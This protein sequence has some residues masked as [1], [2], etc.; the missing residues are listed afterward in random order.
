MKIKNYIPNFITSLNMLSGFVSIIL[1]TQN[2]YHLAIVF[3]LLAALFDVL[4]GL[5]ARYLNSTSKIG[6]QLD[7][8]SDLVSFGVAPA[9]LLYH[10]KLNELGI[11][12][13]IISGLFM[14]MG[15]FR[16]ARFNVQLVGFNKDYFSGIPIPTGAILL[17]SF[18]YNFVINI[19]LNELNNSYYLAAYSLFISLMMVSTVKYPTLETF[20]KNLKLPKIFSIVFGIII[21]IITIITQGKFVF[22]CFLFYLVYGIF[23]SLIKENKNV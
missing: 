2:N 22:Y 1:S 13:M 14:L 16:L 23:N 15:G 12:G 8:L 7:S 18:I 9:F 17:L 19:S 10:I 4:D 21:A 3:I 5:S 11:A 20:L 6:V